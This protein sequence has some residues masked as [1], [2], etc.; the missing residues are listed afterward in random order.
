MKKKI[1]FVSYG[2]GHINLMIPIIKLVIASGKY[3]VEVLGLSVAMEALKREQI[4]FKG[5]ADFQNEIM[6]DAAWKYGKILADRW[7]TDGKGISRLDSEIYLGASMR[8]LVDEEGEE[9]A[10][11]RLDMEGRRAFYPI[12]SMRRIIDRIKPDFIVTTS[13]PRFERAAV[14]VAK[15]YGIA[16]LSVH[17]F[18]AFEFKHILEADTVAVMCDITME[19]LVKWG[20]D[21]AKIVITG[22]PAFDAI[23][24]EMTSFDNQKLRA[25]WGLPLN[26]RFVLLGSQP[27]QASETM[28]KE[29]IKAINTIDG[30]DLVIKPHP[31][32]D[33][34]KHQEW[35]GGAAN[36][37]LVPTA[38]I[39][40]LIFCSDL[41]ITVF[42][43]VGFEAVLMGKPL[44][45]LNLTGKPNPIPLY[46]FGVAM[47]IDAVAGLLPGIRKCLFDAECKEGMSRER[48]KH[49]DKILT[50]NGARNIADIIERGAAR[51]SFPAGLKG[52]TGTV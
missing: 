46:K 33:P 25:K 42:S 1:F 19:N 20:H 52:V 6:D 14:K 4:P 50:G 29:C 18:L 7:H 23:I 51:S 43:T 38:P 31:G 8:D 32:E 22:Q 49:F 27:E 5:I 3:D 13:S 11:K 26:R 10:F 24:N 21:P 15:E 34:R 36:V 17:D 2:A 45:Q 9:A 12:A 39:R 37:H 16:T 30:Y 28:V 48:K 35:I 44:I 40:E 41:T 47:N